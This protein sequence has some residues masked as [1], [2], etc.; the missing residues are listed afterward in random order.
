M[1]QRDWGPVWSAGTQ[2]LHS[3]VRIPCCCG[4]SVGAAAALV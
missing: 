2:A 4:F 1:A 3:G